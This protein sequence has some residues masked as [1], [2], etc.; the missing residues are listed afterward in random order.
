MPE[1]IYIDVILGPTAS[2][3]SA[4]ALELAQDKNGVV[5]NADSMQVY[6]ALP[7]LTARPTP[8]EEALAPHA[9]YGVLPPQ[10]KCTAQRWRDMAIEIIEKTF[11][12]GQHP[13]L[14]GGTGF[15]IK[16]LTEG[17]SPIPDVADDITKSLTKLCEDIGNEAF[18]EELKQ[19]D[20]IMAEKLNPSDTQR[21]IRARAVLEATGQSLAEWQTLPKQK[22]PANWHFNID[23]IKPNRTLLHDK[24]NARL[25][26]MI[27]LGALD[28]VTD[29]SN[30]IDSGLVPEDAPITKAHGFRPFRKYLKGEWTLEE[31]TEQTK[32]EIR[33][34]AKRQ[35]TWL[36]N[37]I[38]NETDRINLQARK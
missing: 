14:A 8:Q 32:T 33:Q 7:I 23:I 28:E 2:G 16:A 26:Y 36:R 3:K 38:N 15:Y 19:H 12:N 24:I 10:E 25:D 37:Q 5:I 35:E 20:P 9:L 29:L 13:I 22:P 4:K 34:Y 18:F 21:I 11:K 1:K 17:L 6:D 30:K 31:A 27:D